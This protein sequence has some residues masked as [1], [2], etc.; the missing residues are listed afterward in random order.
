MGWFSY[1]REGTTIARERATSPATA[2]LSRRPWKSTRP[3]A[4]R[5]ASSSSAAREGPSPATS[6]RTSADVDETA[7]TSVS[8]PFSGESLPAKTN[9]TGWSGGGADGT[10]GGV[11][12]SE[13]TLAS[14]T[15]RSGAIPERSMTSRRKWL[16]LTKRSTPS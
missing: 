5:C 1:Q 14:V 7:S 8:T 16:G 12:P 6:S 3:G 11:S 4:T 15:M 2:A 13:T 10:G 9:R